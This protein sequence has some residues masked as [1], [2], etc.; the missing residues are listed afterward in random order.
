MAASRAGIAA[1]QAE[2]KSG[3]LALSMSVLDN[4]TLPRVGSYSERPTG[5]LYE[6]QRRQHALS[7]LQTLR[8]RYSRLSQP[9]SHLSGSNQQSTEFPSSLNPRRPHPSILTEPPTA[10]YH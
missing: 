4:M 6:R 3:G 9:I 2:P 8:G 5:L 7:L 1:V 10:I